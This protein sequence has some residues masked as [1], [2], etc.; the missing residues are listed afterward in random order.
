MTN[1]PY[2]DDDPNYSAE[3]MCDQHVRKIPSEIVQAGFSVLAVLMP[4]VINSARENG[5][6]SVPSP[7]AVIKIAK[8]HLHPF[9]RWMMLCRGNFLESLERALAITVEFQKRYEK[10][11]K[12]VISLKWLF[13]HIPDFN[14]PVWM[15]WFK[16]ERIGYDG[17]RIPFVDWFERY[18]YYK[19]KDSFKSYVWES[20][21]R[22]DERSTHFV[23][24]MNKTVFPGCLVLEDAVS[25]WRKL[26]IMKAGGKVDGFHS[27]QPMKELI[28][29][30]SNRKPPSWLLD[31]KVEIKTDVVKN[32]KKK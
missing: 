21:D 14:A 30:C 23:Q 31:A 5:L 9:E 27:T 15:K 29:Y 18:G 1:L 10:I 8:N 32:I 24:V 12:S 26:Y 19:S 4:E 25:A 28:S 22:N 17:E 3:Q 20:K 11:H 13:D 7:D 16:K 6:T 2:L